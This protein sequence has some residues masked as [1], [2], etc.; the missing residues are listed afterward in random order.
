MNLLNYWVKLN[1]RPLVFHSAKNRIVRYLLNSCEARPLKVIAEQYTNAV[2]I[3][4]ALF[5]NTA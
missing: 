2:V 1:G 4:R 5:I 3:Y